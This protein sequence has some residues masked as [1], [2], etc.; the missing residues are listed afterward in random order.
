MARRRRISFQQPCNDM[1]ILSLFLLL[2]IAAGCSDSNTATTNTSGDGVTGTLVGTII[3]LNDYRGRSMSDKSGVLVSCEGTSYSALT[4]SDGNWI[5]HDLPSRTYVISFS[6]PGFYTWKDLGFPFT[7]GGVMRYNNIYFSGSVELGEFAKF[8]VTLDAVIMPKGTALGGIYGH[9]SSNTP[10]SAIVGMHVIFG[11]TPQL[12][13]EDES[14]YLL[15]YNFPNGLTSPTGGRDTTVSLASV[16]NKNVYSSMG[17]V[18]G[19]TVY[20]RAYP[21]LG[22]P[23]AIYDPLTNKYKQIGYSLTGSNVLSGIME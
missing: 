20:V 3:R 14:S 6:K 8:T 9:T 23:Q 19:E 2:V 21:L 10:D 11:R 16:M 1:K 17:F 22:N 13:A 18:S 12:T 7:G 4:D 5:I 15:G